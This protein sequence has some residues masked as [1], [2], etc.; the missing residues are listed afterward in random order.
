MR[1]L[2]IRHAESEGNAQGRLQGRKE[3]PLSGRGIAQAAALAERLSTIPIAAV[4]ASP[5]RRA[6]DTAEAVGT[7]LE[8]P[9]LSEQRVQEYD[10]GEQLSG[11]TWQEIRDQQPEVVTS[12]VSGGAEFPAYPGEEGREAFRARVTAAMAEIA[13]RHAAD[14][15]VAVVTHAGPIIVYL[16][17]VLGR[18]YTRPIPFAIDNA[19]ITTIEFAANPTPYQPRAVVTAINDTCHLTS[20]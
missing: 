6:L 1:L 9:V 19:S 4:Y 11:L 20:E 15:E 10:F 2:L 18:A 12:L 8:L 7:R 14:E 13:E 16:M 17:E 3:F 5:I